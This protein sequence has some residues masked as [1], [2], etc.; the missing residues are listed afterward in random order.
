M[1]QAIVLPKLLQIG[2]GAL[3]TVGEIAIQLGCRRV[4]IVSDPV[5][6]S[7]GKVERLQKIIHDAGVETETFTDTIPE[8]TEASILPAV[9]QAIDGHYDGVVALGGGSVIDSA[10]AIALLAKSQGRI[11]DYSVPNV[12]TM[13]IMPLIA[14]PTTAGTGSE[15]TKVTIITDESN[16][17]KLLCMGPGLI[18]AAAVIDFELTMTAPARITA[19]TGIDALT[20]AI[21]AYVSGKAGLFTDQQ[22]LNA[23]KLIAPNLREAVNNPANQQA[24]EQ[25]MLGATLA[26]IA[27]SNA[28]VAL[29][30]GMSRPIGAH[31]HVPHGM[32]NAMLL[33]TVTEYSIPAAKVRYAECAR[34]MELADTAISDDQAVERLLKE[35]KQLN[36]DLGVPSM[37]E[38]GIDHQTYLNCLETM[39]EQALASGSPNNNPRVPD[40]TAMIALYKAAW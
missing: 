21:E 38:F 25:M 13:P 12:V 9:T 17:E 39:A 22:A 19:D 26:G 6:Q 31:F 40:K 27:F 29:V 4:M 15:V 5:M 30:H 18:P 3:N 24:K 2:Q 33:P 16:D 23:M 28:S 37:A 8:P 32:S 20:H 36:V 14:I 34:A 1:S 10:K 35:L 11:R 7:L